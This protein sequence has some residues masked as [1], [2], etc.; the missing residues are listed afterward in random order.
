MIIELVIGAG[1]CWC[2]VCSPIQALIRVSTDAE[3]SNVMKAI[4]AKHVWVQIQLAP[5]KN[6]VKGVILTSQSQLPT[7][8]NHPFLFS[9]P[10]S[11]L[12]VLLPWKI[13]CITLKA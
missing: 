5:S 11:P 1:E 3:E 13:V 7:R 2:K 10:C 6:P 4:H 12:D 9:N 8:P